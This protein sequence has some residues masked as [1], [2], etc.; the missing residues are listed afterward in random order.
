MAF[1]GIH[2]E[3]VTRTY[4]AKYGEIATLTRPYGAM[5][6]T[7]P[8]GTWTF[9]YDEL[10]RETAAQPPGED[11]FVTAYE[12]LQTTKFIGSVEKGYRIE[13]EVGR[14]VQTVAIEPTS[15]IPG[16]K[17]YTGFDY[18]PCGQIRHVTEP[19]GSV[20]TL[21]YDHLGNRTEVNDP[22]AGDRIFGLNAFGEVLTAQYPGQS[23]ITYTRDYLGRVT[24]IQQDA[25]TT[26]YQWDTSPYGVGKLDFE[27]GPTGIV[28]TMTYQPNG[29]PQTTSWV[30]DGQ[31][32]SFGWSYDSN[33]R[34]QQITYPNVGS[35]AP[36]AATIG[37]GGDGRFGAVSSGGTLLWSKTNVTD[38]GETALEAFANDSM[39]S[40]DFDPLTG[41]LM[42]IASGTGDEDVDSDGTHSFSVPFESL[43]YTRYSDGKLKSRADDMLANSEQFIYDNVGR[44]KNWQRAADATTLT[45]GYD[46]SG[47]IRTMSST[48]QSNN[49]TV[50]SYGYGEHGAGPHAVTSGPA[51]TYGYDASGRQTSRPGFSSMGYTFFD[52]PTSLTNAAGTTVFGYD[53]EFRRTVKSGPAGDIVTLLGLYERRKVN[54]AS[55]QV[56]YLPGDRKMVGQVVCPVGG[57]CAA[58]EFFHTDRLGTVDTIT[59]NASVIGRQKRGPFGSSYSGSTVSIDGPAVTLG[60]VGQTEDSDLGLVNMN[61]RLYDAQLGRF[62]SPDPLVK[63]TFDGQN[64]NRYTYAEND[65]LSFVDPTGLEDDTGGDDD[66][67]AAY[68][69]SIA[70]GVQDTG[71][72]ETVIGGEGEDADDRLDKGT[73][74][75][76]KP[77]QVYGRATR[78]GPYDILVKRMV[79]E[80]PKG[81]HTSGPS[82]G[83]ASRG[84]ADW[85][86]ASVGI[87]AGGL[88]PVQIPNIGHALA[89]AVAMQVIGPAALVM[90]L[91]GVHVDPNALRPFPYSPSELAAGTAIEM[92]IGLVLGGVLGG[93][94]EVGALA[95]AESGGAAAAEAAAEAAEAG[96]AAE[97]GEAGT[98]T[99]AAAESNGGAAAG[100]PPSGGPPGEYLA[101]K[102]PTQV[103]PGTRTLQGQHVND[104][105]RVEPWKAHY[106]EY[107]RLVGRTDYN[108]GNKAAGIPSTHYHVYDWT[109][110]GAAGMEV[111]SHVPGEYVP[112]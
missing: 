77:G 4:D 52:L 99:G 16:G 61:H 18:A 38:E 53:A 5:G 37:Y 110:P 85:S 74:N 63:N 6:G 88:P 48:D 67:E 87:N 10:G 103:T 1:D 91:L 50:Q 93:L 112:Q 92:G 7:T 106:D 20:L 111:E 82:V 27:V 11:A 13:D 62:I 68:S 76:L 49:T 104:L 46:D 98:A 54:G 97:A 60:F 102:A 108:A 73:V 51:G 30:A 3:V 25:S 94:G 32:F 39:E 66:F 95:A 43:R 83:G 47:N 14:V 71:S 58:P 9:A 36:F 22:D 70:A 86:G 79:F 65:P 72:V 17:I 23:L 75:G 55:S 89:N 100:G 19:N 41:H 64:Y 35:G 12:G 57:T 90:N 59:S 107:G 78:I 28:T 21:S 101:G 56:F 80:P 96:A 34:L 44:V 40:H 109:D 26:S 45:Y 33:G 29:L 31:V 8:G 105:G 42:R 81:S 2:T 84:S 24:A 69:S 15:V